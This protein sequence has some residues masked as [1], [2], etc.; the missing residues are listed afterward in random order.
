MRINKFQ[1]TRP[2]S[3]RLVKQMLFD[4][5]LF[6]DYSGG[7][8]DAHAQAN[9]A[10]YTLSADSSP[11]KLTPLTG[12]AKNFS[13]NALT[14]FVGLRLDQATDQKQ[15]VIFG[16][17]HQY[18]WPMRLRQHARIAT[19]DWRSSLQR[20]LEGD[21]SSGLPRL[22]IPRRYCR[23]FNEFSQQASFWTPFHGVANAYG[24]SIARPRES[25]QERFRLTELVKPIQGEARPKPADAVG[26]TGEGVV[27]GQTICG[28]RQIG[29]MLH[30]KDIAWWPFDGLDMNL[31]PY[32]G[33]HVGVEIYPSAIRQ[34]PM[35]SDDH[36]ASET[37][38]A[39]R[40]VDT[41]GRLGSL[42][43]LNIESEE[44]KQRILIEGWIVGMDPSDIRNA[45]VRSSISSEHSVRP[46]VKK[47]I[48]VSS[49]RKFPCPIDGCS[50]VFNGTR[51]GWDS[52]VASLK[53][54]KQWRR[55]LKVPKDRK[56]AFKEQ[57]PKFFE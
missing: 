31:P 43:R 36:D 28:L 3:K 14:D 22:D 2:F 55:D 8:E 57:F 17:D 40:A 20:L 19:L 16:F 4:Q 21:E 15:R 1:A 7:G 44:V 30:R 47:A 32:V 50:H 53:T 11:E 39:V 46:R 42:L 6:A 35:Q 56:K 29:R 54:H 52:H 23:L 9:I 48:A 12:Y 5:Y 34:G 13:R 51:G 33:K 25:I 49:C 45:L 38:L 37:C 24:V 41:S 27:G 18:A 10:L 26:G